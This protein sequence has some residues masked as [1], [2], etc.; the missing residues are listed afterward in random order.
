MVVLIPE[1][2]EGDDPVQGKG[3]VWMEREEEYVHWNGKLSID[4]ER[5]TINPLLQGAAFLRLNG[6]AKFEPGEPG[7]IG[8]ESR[9]ALDMYST[10][11]P[12]RPRRPCRGNP[13]MTVPKDGI[14][15]ADFNGKSFSHTIGELLQGSRLTS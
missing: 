12:T 9:V 5:S 2:P 1:I 4:R 3:G 10:K 14:L 7:T 15:T 6:R 13:R 11:T 8:L